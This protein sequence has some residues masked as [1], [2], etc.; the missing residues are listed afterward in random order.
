MMRRTKLKNQFAYDKMFKIVHVID[1]VIFEDDFIDGQHKNEILYGLVRMHPG[2][3]ERLYSELEH[4]NKDVKVLLDK[5]LIEFDKVFDIIQDW[6]DEV[7]YNDIETAICIIEQSGECQDLI[8]N[9]REMYNAINI[10]EWKDKDRIMHIVSSYGI[11]VGIPAS[12]DELFDEYIQKEKHWEKFRIFRDF[13]S[14]TEDSF[15]QYISGAI[16]QEGTVV[17][18]IDDQMRGKKCA[19]EIVDSI[20]KVTSNSE[21][22][23]NIIGLIFSTFENEDCISDR[24]F[25]EYI[26][27]KESRNDFQIALIKSAYSFMLDRLKKIYI[28][29]LEQSFDDAIKNK[30]MA[31]YL[32]SMAAYEGVTNYQVISNWIKL[33]F[34]YK[35]SDRNELLTIAGM[36]RLIN[37]LEDEKV[38]FSKDMLALN[39]FEAF[40]FNVNKYHEP[41]ASGDLFIV[42][43]KKIYI[44][45]GQECDMMNSMTRKRKNGI[46]ELIFAST[47]LQKN[48][49]NSV[50][51]DSKNIYISNFQKNKDAA[52]KTLKVQY[53]SREFIENQ[54]LQ[55]CQFNTEGQ[56]KIDLNEKDYEFDG[57]EPTYYDEMYSDLLMYFEALLKISIT[58]SEALSVI[59]SSE[60]S[61][62]LINL[63][64]YDKTKKQKKVIEYPIQ[65]ICRIK[66]PY[67]L[68]IYK[69][70]LEYQGRHSFDCMNMTRIQEIQVRTVQNEHVNLCIDVILTP[71]REV[72]RNNVDQMEWYVDKKAL[73]ETVSQ[74]IN[75]P[76]EILDNNQ[77]IKIEL[78]KTPFE[79]R[80]GSSERRTMYIKKS[81]DM[82][83]IE[84]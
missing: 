83:S 63:L 73:E 43:K 41:V 10:E 72:N 80:L 12:Y 44:L 29:V 71:D 33:L 20:E 47:V 9:I 36:I 14:D 7:P 54:I 46:S 2:N 76:A 81:D 13:F 68:Y 52:V 21:E 38:E 40:D 77:N 69:M 57:T 1:I 56:C 17:C 37:F 74:L 25:F 79:C 27:K 48:I 62:R 65:R 66:H 84:Y 30:H 42:N 49:D 3:R 67:M 55:L 11:G 19:R 23:L 39:T 18:I 34:D 26:N 15:K 22:R 70:Y 31:Y 35:L 50:F 24:V 5:F 8:Y 75:G 59:V 61:K 53:S 78:E 64:E 60:Q 51:L 6:D 32:S 16:E 58:D 28:D 82:V 4:V 45:V